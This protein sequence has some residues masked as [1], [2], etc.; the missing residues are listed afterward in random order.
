MKN[1]ISILGLLLMIV[2]WLLGNAKEYPL[3][4][5]IILPEYS[6]VL[7]GLE[8]LNKKDR[9]LIESDPGF[10]EI[11]EYVKS[12]NKGNPSTDPVIQNISITA[13]AQSYAKELKT[14]TTL[15]IKMSNYPS[16]DANFTDFHNKVKSAYSDSFLTKCDLIIFIIGIIVIITGIILGWEK[17]KSTLLNHSI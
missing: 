2:G 17:R 12:T 10:D 3:V 11:S 4:H 7:K 8:I 13:T 9:Q 6:A 14:I 1:L 15:R 5:C 16:V